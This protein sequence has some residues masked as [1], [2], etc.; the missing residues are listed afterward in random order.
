M[1]PVKKTKIHLNRQKKKKSK[2]QNKFIIGL[3]ILNSF[4]LILLLVVAITQL[5]INKELIRKSV[6][7]QRPVYVVDS[8]PVDIDAYLREY[9][10][11][12]LPQKTIYVNVTAY[13]SN[14]DQTDGN[15]YT[16]AYGTPARDGIVAAN[17]L[18]VGTVVR[19]P[20]KFGDKLFVAEDRMNERY[21]FQVD[22][23]MSDQEEAKKFGIQFLKMEVF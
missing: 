13:S 18:P 15:P 23:W 1:S 12:K 6:T 9:F 5:F 21:S 10:V 19:F 2:F 22:I 16:T 14:K 20:D 4:F 3:F 17:F 7:I 11:N 8:Q